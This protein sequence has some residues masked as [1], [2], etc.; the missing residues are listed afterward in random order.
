VAVDCYVAS[1]P[2][3]AHYNHEFWN[4]GFAGPQTS[5]L[6]SLAN[7]LPS[8]KSRD[9]G[10]NPIHASRR[11]RDYRDK[12]MHSWWNGLAPELER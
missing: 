9:L 8:G 12:T 5:Y 7:V 4:L 2:S 3:L 10:E 6:I 11:L 1:D